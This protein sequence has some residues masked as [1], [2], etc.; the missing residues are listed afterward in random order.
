MNFF[1]RFSEEEKNHKDTIH[2]ILE[3]QV[4]VEFPISK[5]TLIS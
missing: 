4:T 2:K 1:C 5:Q 3:I